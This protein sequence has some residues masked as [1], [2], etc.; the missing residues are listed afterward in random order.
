MTGRGAVPLAVA[1]AALA[2]IVPTAGSGQTT[3][4]KITTITTAPG[5][6]VRWIGD[7]IERCRFGDRTFQAIDG[8]CLLPVDLGAT[9]ELVAERTAGGREQRLRVV[10]GA[11]PYS[12]QHIKIEDTSRVDVSPEN[13][14]RAARESERIAALWP[15]STALRFHLPLGPPLER[16]GKAGRFGARRVFN[17]QPRGPHTGADYSAAKGTPVLATDAGEVM[18]A[19]EHFFAGNSVFIDHGDGL[20]S[21]VFHL[22]SI[23]VR[24]GQ[25]VARGDKLGTVGATGRATG[26]HLHFGLRWRGARIDPAALLG[27]V[28]AL[29][30]AG[31]Q[32]PP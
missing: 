27:P 22:D 21:M 11:Y 28:A 17:G 14:A 5:S 12:E 1:F 6:V 31:D 8:A 10:V 16:P 2:C 15:R 30:Q 19:E 23:A 7:G 20:I 32:A 26:P 24:P 25:I 18:L 4:P 9:G 13:E 3:E 29:P